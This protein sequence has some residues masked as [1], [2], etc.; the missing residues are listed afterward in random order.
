MQ[1][2]ESAVKVAY[3][4]WHCFAERRWDDAR[5][6][7]ADDFEAHWPQSREKIFDPDNFIALNHDYP[8][9]HEITT[10][11]HQHSYDRWDHVD[12]VTTQVSII[13]T[14]PDGKKIELFAVSF[15]EIE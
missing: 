8:G 11:D 1:G 3:E 13:S 2:N 7:L 5:K 12:H 6:L 9:V 4:L 15:F 14:M 10:F